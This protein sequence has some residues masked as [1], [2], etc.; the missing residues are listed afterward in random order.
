MATRRRPTCLLSHIFGT[1]PPLWNGMA[2]LELVLHSRVEY[3]PPI[4][5]CLVQH[6][7]RQG[8]A[9]GLGWKSGVATLTTCLGIDSHCCCQDTQACYKQA[10]R[11]QTHSRSLFTVKP[12]DCTF[13][14]S[15]ARETPLARSAFYTHLQLDSCLGEQ[16]SNILTDRL[17]YI[18]QSEVHSKT[19]PRKDICERWLRTI[20]VES[21]QFQGRK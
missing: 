6:K 10:Q 19:E 4:L 3:F 2:H 17:F 12:E 5:S 1:L 14:S 18:R 8:K 15:L 11:D 7:P 20:K 9:S 16:F 21:D 13:D